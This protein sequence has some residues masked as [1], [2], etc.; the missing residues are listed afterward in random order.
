MI[1]CSFLRGAEGM[2]S[3]G[4][5]ISSRS[6]LRGPADS[7][8]EMVALLRRYP[9]RFLARLV[10]FDIFAKRFLAEVP[11]S[12]TGSLLRPSLGH[13]IKYSFP[14]FVVSLLLVNI[15]ILAGDFLISSFQFM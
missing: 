3:P 11:W 7:V 12:V 10:I 9:L 1:C 2:R 8:T 13:S 4:G 5:A 14:P 15:S 6:I